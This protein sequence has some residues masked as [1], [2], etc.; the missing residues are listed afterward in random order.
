[1]GR[2]PYPGVDNF[3]VA[4]YLNDGNRLEQP[5]LCSNEMLVIFTLIFY[6]PS[7]ELSIAHQFSL[8]WLISEVSMSVVFK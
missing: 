3:E 8:L 4:K 1:M 2:Q 5:P 7:V 6:T